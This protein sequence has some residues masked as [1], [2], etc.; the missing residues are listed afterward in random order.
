MTKIPEVAVRLKE[1][2]AEPILYKPAQSDTW[3]AQEVANWA[4][5]VKDTG[6]KLE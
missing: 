2:G 5:V 4:K 6:I 1:L 3:R